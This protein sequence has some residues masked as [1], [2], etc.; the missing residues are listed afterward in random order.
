MN[1]AQMFALIDSTVARLRELSR[2]KGEEYTQGS[3]E[4]LA[5]FIEGGKRTGV[6]ALQYLFIQ[7]DK[8]YNAVANYVKDDSKGKTRTVSEPIDGRLDD[9]ILYAILMKGLAF[10]N[11]RG[12]GNLP[13]YFRPP[14]KQ[15]EPRRGMVHDDRYNDPRVVRPADDAEPDSL[16]SLQRLVRD[17]AQRTFPE[18]S[19]DTV[20]LKLTTHEMPELLVSLGAKKE[21]AKIPDEIADVMIL[22]LDYCEMKGIDMN[23]VIRDKMAVNVTRDWAVDSHGISSHVPKD[24]TNP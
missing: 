13:T 24:P 8:H 6:T 22:L 17:W 5:N 9:L 14:D 3:E 21:S 12:A 1:T 15:R 10:Q 4:R 11:E 23:R 16:Q 18:R 20:R 2:T 19:L 7:L